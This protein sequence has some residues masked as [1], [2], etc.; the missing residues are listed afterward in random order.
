MI[1]TERLILRQWRDADRDPFAALNADPKVMLHFP[2]TLTR[3][4]SDAAV[5]RQIAGIAAHGHGFWAVERKAD[6]AFL[7]FTGTKATGPDYP[8]DGRPEVGW[9]L[10]RHAWGAGYASE[11]AR[12]SLAHAFALIDAGEIV[13][14][15]PTTNTPS[16]AVMKRIGMARAE[17]LDFDHPALP[18]G[19][20]LRRHIV[21][22]L[23]RPS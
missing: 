9:R 7:G 19:H 5:D 1:E 23:R 6:G 18:E 16:Q 4:E 20:R 12:A 2:A 15:T 8:L 11:A 14:F 21:Y 22:A 10:A 13:A 3:Q 17:H